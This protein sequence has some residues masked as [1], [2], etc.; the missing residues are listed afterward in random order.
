[1]L[2]VDDLIAAYFAAIER[3]EE[4]NGR[5]FN[6]GGGPANTVSILGLVHFLERHLGRELPIEFYDWR[7]GDQPVYISDI[8]KAKKELGWEPK[9]DPEQGVA[10][11]LQWVQAINPSSRNNWG[12][13][14]NKQWQRG[15][16]AEPGCPTACGGIGLPDEF[17][18]TFPLLWACPPVV[19]EG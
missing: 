17:C 11:L 4:M 1:M 15:K 7:P 3:S 2:H 13:C 19:G 10:Q 14:W 9:I 8:S 12:I 6:I 16:G 18:P 5:I